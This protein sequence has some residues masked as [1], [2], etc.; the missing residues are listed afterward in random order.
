MTSRRAQRGQEARVRLPAACVARRPSFGHWGSRLS[1]AVK[2]APEPGSLRCA[3]RAKIPSAPSA[4][5]APTGQDN[6]KP[7]PAEPAPH[8]SRRSGRATDSYRSRPQTM[9]TVLTQI[10]RFVSGNWVEATAAGLYPVGRAARSSLP[11][12]GS[13]GAQSDPSPHSSAQRAAERDGLAYRLQSTG[14][15]RGALV[16]A[17]TERKGQLGARTCQSAFGSLTYR[18]M[19]RIRITR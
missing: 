7:G 4:A 17:P 11:A 9:L 8:D 15:A 16:S 14:R 3:R 13:A 1:S 2:A 18:R 6:L 12:S 5:S 10:P 19:V